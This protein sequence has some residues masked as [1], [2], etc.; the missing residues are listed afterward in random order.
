M[1]DF[2]PRHPT[3][4]PLYAKHKDYHPSKVGEGFF[5]DAFLGARHRL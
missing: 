3:I 5:Q 2:Q 4:K 1:E